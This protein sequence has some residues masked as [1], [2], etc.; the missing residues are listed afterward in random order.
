MHGQPP[1]RRRNARTQEASRERCGRPCAVFIYALVHSTLFTYVLASTFSLRLF[2]PCTSGRIRQM[3]H[4]SASLKNV[5]V[6][7]VLVEGQRRNTDNT[8]SA[9][10][11]SVGSTITAFH[12]RPSNRHLLTPLTNDR[13]PV[14]LLESEE[15]SVMLKLKPYMKLT[16][17]SSLLIH[18]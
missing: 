17:H 8:N 11:K 10:S 12:I 2:I 14:L 5:V 13:S 15:T 6:R 1:R 4:P 16:C 9:Y 3:H 7:K 18:S